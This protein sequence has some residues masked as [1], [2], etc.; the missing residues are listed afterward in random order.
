MMLLLGAAIPHAVRGQITITGMVADSATMQPLPNVNIVSIKTGK[1]I[2]SDLRGA[3][4]LQASEGDS[5]SFSRVGYISKIL[6]VSEIRE[7]VIIFLKEERRMLK[8]VEILDSTRVPWLPELPPESAWQN[9]ASGRSFT[10][11]PGFQ[12]VQ[13][14]GPGYVFKGVFSRMSKGEKEKRK[15]ARVMEENYE[16]SDYVKLVNDRSV[17]GKIMKEYGLSDEEYY[18]LLARFNEKYGNSIYGLEN[19]E[20][21]ALLLRFYSRNAP[22]AKT[23]DESH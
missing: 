10:A 14:F 5:I 2:V 6:P 4:S 12:G 19:H 22:T 11:A 7:L 3:F 20:I 23:H 18:D 17:K 15:L 1:G 9:T 16:A 21:V 13:T 8:T